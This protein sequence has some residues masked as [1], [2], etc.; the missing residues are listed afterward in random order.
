IYHSMERN[1][2]CGLGKCGHCMMGEFYI[3]KDGPVMTAAQIA[4]FDDPF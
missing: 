3:C 1:M 4:E 2:S